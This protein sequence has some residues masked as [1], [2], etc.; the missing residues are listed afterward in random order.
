MGIYFFSLSYWFVRQ[1]KTYTKFLRTA[2]IVFSGISFQGIY[3]G[4]G[5]DSL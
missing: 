3:S 2:K 5:R 1:D 4:L